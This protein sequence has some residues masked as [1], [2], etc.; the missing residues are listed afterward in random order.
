M[1]RELQEVTGDFGGAANFAVQQHQRA[2]ALGIEWAAVEQIGERAD[3]GESV[4]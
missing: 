4:V 3:G 1:G 2:G